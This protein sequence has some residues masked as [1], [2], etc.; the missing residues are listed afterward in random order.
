[1]APIRELLN[2]I[3]ER[4]FKFLYEGYPTQSM[5]NAFGCQ[6]TNVRK[7]CCKYEQNGQIVKEYY[8]RTT[9]DMNASE[10]E[11]RNNKS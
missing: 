2:E 6:E 1:M 5:S 11:T 10:Q 7:I 9:E 8:K 3:M 4:I